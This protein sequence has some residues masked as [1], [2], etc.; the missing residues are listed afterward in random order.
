MIMPPKETYEDNHNIIERKRNKYDKNETTHRQII[1]KQ[2]FPV[3]KCEILDLPA[4]SYP[5]R[6]K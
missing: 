5:S 3:D 1:S 6:R 4:T 2:F